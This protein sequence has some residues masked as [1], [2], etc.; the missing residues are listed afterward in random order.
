MTKEGE[1]PVTTG[2]ERWFSDK[3]QKEAV[4]A[5]KN[6]VFSSLGTFAHNMRE[7]DME[8]NII[9]DFVQKNGTLNELEPERL[10]MIVAMCEAAD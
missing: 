5:Q 2:T 7:F 9:L 3:E 4:D 1:G 10:A 8:K 6:F